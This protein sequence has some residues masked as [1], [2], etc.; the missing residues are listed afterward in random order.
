MEKA[1]DNP[2]MEFGT[3]KC[4]VGTKLQKYKKIRVVLRGDIVK[5]DSGAH[6][7]F[8]EQGSSASQMTVAKNNGHYCKISK[9]LRTSSGR[10]ICLYSGKIGG[11]SQ[12][13]QNSTVR[14]SR[15]TD[16][17]QDI[18]GPKSWSSTEDPVVPLELNLC[19]HPLAGLVWE[20]QFEEALENLDGRKDRIGNVYLFIDNK[21]YFLSVLV[22]DIKMAGKNQN[23]APMWNKSMKNVDID[24]PTSFLDHVY[25]GW[26]Q[27]ECK[28]NEATAGKYKK[29][30]ESRI[31]AG[32]TEK[33]P[34]CEKPH[35]KTVAWSYDMEGHAQK[36]VE[37]YCELA[38]KKTEQLCK[39]SSLCLDDHHF[40]KE[41]LESVGE[42]CE[43]CSRIVW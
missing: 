28:P 31:S 10:S 5:D 26:T 11:C 8:T 42:L 18:N 39:V 21:G 25:L 35:A 41:E 4:G 15:Y 9:M 32:A 12:I 24:E 17:L 13:A 37:K 14:V 38:N 43:V 20:R 3:S 34:G 19:G 40:K 36:C 7:I 22:D 33:S 23:M 6:A 16:I 2:S 27:R 29:M 30:F 1:R